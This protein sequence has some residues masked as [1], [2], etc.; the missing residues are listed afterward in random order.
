MQHEPTRRQVLIAATGTLGATALVG[1]ASSAAKAPPETKKWRIGLNTSSVHA[2]GDDAVVTKINAAA[3]AGY[4]AIEPWVRDIDK[5][6]KSGGSLDDLRKRIADADMI[7]PSAVAYFHWLFS[8]DEKWTAAL[9]EVK[10]AMEHV[11]AIGG[12]GIV[13]PPAGPQDP[14]DMPDAGR[15]YR[16]LLEIGEQIGVTPFVE[17][18]GFRETVNRLGE[19]AGIAIEA[20][21]PRAGIVPDIYHLY[22]GGSGF[23]TVRHLNGA[24]IKG[25]HFNDVP[26]N[27]PRETI[28]DKD[29]VWPGD[30]VAPLGQVLKDLRAIGY[31]GV[32]SLELFNRTY[33]KQDPVT[34]AK[35]G[36][37]KMRKVIAESGTE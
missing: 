19:C 3:A 14:L 12:T 10:R 37:E 27:M 36:L 22:K 33:W 21:H 2:D 34:A 25:F 32:L 30:G 23:D 15:R 20:H 18:W 8:T 11:R 9:D 24:F 31:T 1:D 35:T 13:A 26:A 7:V 29:R 16:K 6:V 28:S 5:Y 17:L 4:D